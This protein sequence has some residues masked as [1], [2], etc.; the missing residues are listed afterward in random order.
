MDTVQPW[1]GLVFTAVLNMAFAVVAGAVASLW[2]LGRSASAWS[3]TRSQS[4]AAVM[5]AALVATGCA[6]ALL[7]WTQAAELSELPLLD[8]VPSISAVVLHSHVGHAWLIGT[9]ALVLSL[10]ATFLHPHQQ[11][12]G[13]LARA[14]AV[15]AVLFAGAKSWMGH[16]GASGELLPFLVDWV[17]LVAVSVWA[18]AVFLA[19]GVVLSG[20]APS[21]VEERG[22]NAVYVRTLSKTATWSVSALLATGV[23]NAWRGLGGSTQP[24]LSSIYGQV[25]LAKLVLVAIAVGL[26]AHNRF[27]AMPR[28]L[29]DLRASEPSPSAASRAFYRV[30]WIESVVL[31]GALWAAAGLST[32][33][34]PAGAQTSF[35]SVG[36]LP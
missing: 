28:L 20:P 25:L 1:L 22:A 13:G 14:A 15:G 26:G 29:N 11:A 30:L 4:T 2:M 8:A 7:L 3:H 27:I 32:S 19:T 33:A 10:G 35:F 21:G 6:F 16:A 5:Q 24:L 34:L 31:V 36:V 9:G 18:G 17:H 12:S 23:F